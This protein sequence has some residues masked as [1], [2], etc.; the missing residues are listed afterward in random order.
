MNSTLSRCFAVLFLMGLGLS[1]TLPCDA[2]HMKG[3]GKK[4]TEEELNSMKIVREGEALE[5]M[6]K[7]DI[8]PPIIFHDPSREVKRG[9]ALTVGA[10]IFDESGVESVT[11]HYRTIGQRVFESL[12]MEPR[13]EGLY[14]AVIPDYIF[15]GE[16]VEY[17]IRAV[18]SRGNPPGHSG[19]EDEPHRATFAS[20]PHPMTNTIAFL[21]LIVGILVVITVPKFIRRGESIV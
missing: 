20:G 17:Y 13:G 3:E 15:I 6:E 11:L 4:M 19:S 16:G 1:V 5:V 21:L 2:I 12:D 14:T 8:D 7:K 18:D 9:K 10:T